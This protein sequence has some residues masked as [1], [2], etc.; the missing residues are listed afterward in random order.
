MPR[1]S[2]LRKTFGRKRLPLF[3]PTG[4]NDGV[5]LNRPPPLT[6]FDTPFAGRPTFDAAEPSPIEGPV[7]FRCRA[8]F[9]S[10]QSTQSDAEASRHVANADAQIVAPAA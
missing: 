3:V 2:R 1:S 9:N 8:V 4:T 5:Y 7:L 10:E 6:R